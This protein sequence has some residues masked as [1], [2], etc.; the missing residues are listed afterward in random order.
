MRSLSS[1]PKSGASFVTLTDFLMQTPFPLPAALGG[2]EMR[3][4]LSIPLFY[5]VPIWLSFRYY[6][7]GERYWRLFSILATVVGSWLG[8]VIVRAIRAGLRAHLEGRV[9]EE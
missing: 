7:K 5:L 9:R 2:D 4:L 3:I 6:G 1:L 8:F